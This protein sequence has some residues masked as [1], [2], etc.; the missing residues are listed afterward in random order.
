MTQ[1][2]LSPHTGNVGLKRSLGLLAITAFGVGDI[3]GAG[4]YGLVGKIA[5]IVGPAAWT[6]YVVAGIAAA[7]TGL[8]YAEF[9]SRFPRAGGAAHFCEAAWRSPLLTFFVIFFVVLSG[10]FS[11]ATAARVFADYSTAMFP[12]VPELLRVRILPVVFIG[13]LAV[14]AARGI[15]L[16]S[17]TN[18]V[19][20]VVE[21]SGL[22]VVIAVAA[23]FLGSANLMEFAPAEPAF[24]TAALPVM[25]ISGASLAFFAFVGFEDMANLAEE[26]KRPE[27]NVPLGI[28][29]AIGITTVIYCAIAL[30]SVSVLPPA[31]LNASKSPVLDVVRAAAPWFPAWIYSVIPGFAVFNTA[32]LNLLMASRLLYGMSRR[33]SRH[34][35]AVFSYVHPRWQTPLVGVAASVAVVGLLLAS[36]LNVAALASGTSTFLLVVFLALHAGL[37]RMKLD[38]SVP[39]SPFRVPALVP[40]AGAI[41]CLALLVRQKPGAI[42][43]A[44][45]FAAGILVLYL[46]NRYVRGR[47]DVQAID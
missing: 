29:F 34:L 43:V 40:A 22:L 18:M 7:L 31:A 19:C 27:R 46:V 13:C 1:E 20:T 17:G 47:G 12:A 30:V 4:V 5:G 15:G 14:V 11:M 32:L 36:G 42:A 24:G 23:R 10:L 25:V 41:V 38:R 2:Q 45:C 21:L 16:S 37:L 3:L 6:S 28:C 26:V 39:V 44:G 9:T 33:D 35:P 8:T